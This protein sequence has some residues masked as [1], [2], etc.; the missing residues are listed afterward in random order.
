[1][2]AKYIN[3]D[4]NNL[5]IYGL[6]S[7]REPNNIKYIGITRRKPSYRLNNHLYKGFYFKTN[8]NER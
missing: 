1:M 2:A 8:K 6:V 4:S 3:I 5:T 7:K